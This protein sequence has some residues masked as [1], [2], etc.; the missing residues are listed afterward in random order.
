MHE[1][2]EITTFGMTKEH[3]QDQT[4]DYGSLKFLAAGGSGV[5]YAIDEERVLK[6]FH[7]EGIEVERRALER[8]GPHVNI[9]GCL[10]ATHDS[11]ILERGRSVR[12]VIQ[13]S[14]ADQI[15]LHTKVRWLCEAAEGTRYMHDNGIIHADIG[16]NNW[17]IVQEHLKIIDFE[18]SSIDGED[19]GACYEWFSY[20]ESSPRISPKTDI[21]AFGCAIYEVLTGKQP[22][23]ELL[24]F[25]DRMIRVKML[26]AKNQFPEVENIQLGKLMQGC[27]NGTFNSMD[28][29]L[30][31]LRASLQDIM[32]MNSGHWDMKAV[33]FNALRLLRIC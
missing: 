23:I 9:V 25:E 7:G 13:G 19:A 10:G 4:I 29:V 1:K 8:L 22:Y 31:E 14:G 30:R 16:C 18:G 15:P 26:Y 32:K 11:L 27:W 2:H 33:F 6:E 28:E 12:T 20:K 21:F 17:I 5:I 3:M 24:P